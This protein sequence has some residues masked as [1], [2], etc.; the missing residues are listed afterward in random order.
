LVPRESVCYK[1]FNK[2]SAIGVSDDEEEEEED[3]NGNAE[4]IQQVSQEIP[5]LETL[6]SKVLSQTKNYFEKN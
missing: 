6:A 2:I 1:T 4:L 3:D 5:E